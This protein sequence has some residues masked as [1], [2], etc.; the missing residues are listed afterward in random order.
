MR[1]EVTRKIY[2]AFQ[3]LEP[4]LAVEVTHNSHDN[5]VKVTARKVKTVSVGVSEHEIAELAN[6]NAGEE[7]LCE[8]LMNAASKAIEKVLND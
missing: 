2:D 7:K 4:G 3:G 1:Y 8:L 6:D 5:G